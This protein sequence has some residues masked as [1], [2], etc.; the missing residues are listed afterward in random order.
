VRLVTGF[1]SA[2]AFSTERLVCVPVRI[3]DAE[4]MVAVLEDLSLYE[5]I[6]GA[7][8]TLRE[9][10]ARYRRQVAGSPDPAQGWLNWV[11]RLASDHRSVGS[12]QAELSRREDGQPAARIAWVIGAPWQHRGYAS[13]AAI[14]LVDWLDTRRVTDVRANIHADHHA[15]GAVAHRAGLEPTDDTCNGEVVWRRNRPATTEPRDPRS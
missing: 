11:V 6:G 2:A 12:L 15:S 8:P 5:F 4:E 9:L 13:E 1:P 10:Q 7:P 3:E 14:G